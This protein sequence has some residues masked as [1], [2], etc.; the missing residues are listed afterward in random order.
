MLPWFIVGFRVLAG[1]RSAG[2]IPPTWVD[3]TRTLS[4]WLTV[5]AMAGL[6]LG[7]D[8]RVLGRV[9]RPVVMAVS[10]SLVVLIVLAVT[11]IRVLGI[12]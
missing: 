7:V 3:P 12:Q 1:V 8:I 11:M 4:G 5:A 6:G 10:G 2:M 9:G